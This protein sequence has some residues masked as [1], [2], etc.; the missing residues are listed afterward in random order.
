MAKSKKPAKKKT[1][2]KAQQTNK[3]RQV[4]VV[5]PMQSAPVAAKAEEPQDFFVFKDALYYP[6]IDIRDESWI[7][8]TALYWD[9][10]TTIVPEGLGHYRES[11][12]TKLLAKEK[13]LQAEVIRPGM[14]ELDEV[15][16]ACLTFIDSPEGAMLKQ[17]QSEPRLLSH[18]DEWHAEV[19]HHN[20]FASRVIKDLKERGIVFEQDGDW[21]RL[22]GWVARYYMTL[23]ASKL[24]RLTG[25]SMLTD[26]VSSEPLANRAQRGDTT[27]QA[28]ASVSQGILA[29][30]VLQTIQIEGNTP[31]KNILRFKEKHADELGLLR[32][33]LREL[34]K[35]VKGN[36]DIE[37]LQKHLSTVYSDQVKPAVSNLQ[38][39]LTD[40]RISSGYN[41][42][43]ATTLFSAGA[44]AASTAL[45]AL[46]LGPFGLLGGVGISLL[47]SIGNYQLQKREILRSS[48]YSYVLRAEEAFGKKKKSS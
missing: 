38:S 21:I 10:I 45:G 19:I 11:D 22:P 15:A 8:T 25:R 4:Q 20:K 26:E 7:K 33:A 9:S 6:F 32:N 29:T 39:R 27:N 5:E 14:K 17:R 36:V 23:L 13:F 43:R 44:T 1:S 40:N 37:V 16:D 41:N 42:L 3:P 46:A 28:P 18:R 31:V 24:S 47:L 48:P 30:L 2:S 35:P 12:T 34:V